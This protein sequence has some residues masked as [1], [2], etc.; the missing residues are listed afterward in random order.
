MEEKYFEATGAT[1]GV[2]T[3]FL[4]KHLHSL[5]LLQKPNRVTRTQFVPKTPI[6]LLHIWLPPPPA[7][8]VSLRNPRRDLLLSAAADLGFFH[9]ADHGVPAHLH[10]SALL[11][12]RSLLA[13]PSPP[14]LS[15]LGFPQIDDDDDEVSDPILVLDVDDR[16]DRGDREG[17]R[18][19][20]EFGRCL[21]R[22][23]MGVVGML[24][25]M[26]AGGFEVD[27]FGDATRARCLMW[28]S[29]NRGRGGEEGEERMRSKRY[30]YVVGLRYEAEEPSWVHGD[31]GEWVAVEPRDYSVLVTLGDIAQVWSNGRFKKVRGLPQPFSCNESSEISI[32]LLL[33][34][35]LDTIISPLSPLMEVEDEE[36]E[37]WN[38]DS[39]DDHGTSSSSSRRRRFRSFSLDEYAWRVYHERPPFKDPLIRYRI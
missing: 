5:S 3:G 31:S 21:K 36:C 9:L 24:A 16:G 19:L 15:P 34:L 17:L 7:P 35:P 14:D 4:G 10:A 26:G 30:P 18:S 33:T 1:P 8:L 39:V 12:S 38:I 13:S 20:V 37:Q 25:A 28:V 23:A 11:E 22:A 6:T 29:T 2:N 27:P 32:T